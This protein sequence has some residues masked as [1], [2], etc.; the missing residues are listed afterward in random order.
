MKTNKLK[1]CLYVIILIFILPIYGQE[2]S[3]FGQYEIIFPNQY[4]I[5]LQLNANKTFDYYWFKKNKFKPINKIQGTFVCDS[6]QKSV[7]L[8]TK[9]TKHL[10]SCQWFLVNEGLKTYDNNQ[11]GIDILY[12]NSNPLLHKY[13]KLTQFQK[14]KKNSEFEKDIHLIFS[15]NGFKG[16]S[17]CNAI[18]G[19]YKINANQLQC[20]YKSNY[21][22]KCKSK[23][24]ETLFLKT[25]NQKLIFEVRQDELYICNLDKK[26]IARF[27]A[28]WLP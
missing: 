24:F 8:K 13:W 7:T 9:K 20:F 16:F 28:V 3:V 26:I 2:K 19:N 10:P 6:L 23:N 11:C 27:E 5:I 12:Y 22:A 15:Q 21:D 18:S 14:Q 25:L 17:G 4:G 1:C